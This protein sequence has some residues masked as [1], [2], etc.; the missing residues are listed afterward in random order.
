MKYKTLFRL[1]VKFLGLVLMVLALLGFLDQA[2]SGA[3]LWWLDE[4]SGLS[5]RI[6]Y[7]EL[8][9]PL[10]YNAVQLVT[11]FLFLAKPNWIV[12]LAIPSNRPY[13]PHCGYDLKGRENSR[14]CPECGVGLPAEM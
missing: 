4:Y 2:S 13:C 8:I 10:I 1:A 5:V 12:N 6:R 11:G 9:P 14:H 3:L 7:A